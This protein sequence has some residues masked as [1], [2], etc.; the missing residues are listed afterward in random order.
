MKRKSP[1][2]YEIREVETVRKDNPNVGPYTL[3]RLIKANH[4][5]RETALSSSHRTFYSILSVIRRYDAR[6]KAVA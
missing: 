3:A 2:P 5:G 1:Y 4:F 6:Q